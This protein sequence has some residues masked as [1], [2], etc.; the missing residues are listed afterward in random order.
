MFKE[1][2]PQAPSFDWVLWIKWVLATT[3]G[4]IVGWA[5][6]EFAVGLTT[7]LAQWVVLRKQIE[8]SEW[9]VLASGIG[10]AAGRGFVTAVTPSQSTILVNAILGAALGLAQWLV[11]QRSVIQ[12][13]WWI[14]VSTLSWIVGLTGFLGATLIGSVVGA[15]T[16]LALEPLLRYSSSQDHPETT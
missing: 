11:L 10:W 6:S 7:G 13:W 3:L 2:D 15:V 1:R 5:I 14:I 4:W 12:A 16:G 8:H 9:W